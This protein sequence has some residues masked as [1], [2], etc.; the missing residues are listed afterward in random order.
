MQKLALS[1]IILL[2]FATIAKAAT[3]TN[4]QVTPLLSGVTATG[5]GT[6]Y[7]FAPGTS[8]RAVQVT[9]AGS[10][11]VSATTVLEVSNAD[12]PTTFV[13]AVTFT[14]SGTTTVSEGYQTQNSWAY[15]RGNVTAISGVG[16]AV[17]LTVGSGN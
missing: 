12:S 13:P 3:N 17:T 14:S 7:K 2:V 15:M 11:V 9:V 4:L 1:L 8:G 5:T 16:A 6:V 10:G